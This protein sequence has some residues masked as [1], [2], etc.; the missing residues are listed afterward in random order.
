MLPLGQGQV[1]PVHQPGQPGPQQPDASAGPTSRHGT[2]YGRGAAAAAPAGQRTHQR[3]GQIYPPVLHSGSPLE[4]SGSLTG[5][6]LAQGRSD[7]PTPKTRTAKVV[8]I[9]AAVLVFLVGMGLFV[10]TIASDAVSELFGGMLGG[11]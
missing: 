9:M 2:V 7:A 4:H 3:E 11:S 5:H 10:A 1:S 8:V 6:I